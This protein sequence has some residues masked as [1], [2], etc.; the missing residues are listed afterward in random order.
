MKDYYSSFQDNREYNT[1]AKHLDVQH[2][3]PGT[4]YIVYVRAVTGGGE[5]DSGTFTVETE[6]GSM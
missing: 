4:N 6:Y 2:L 5:G 1:T 3:Y